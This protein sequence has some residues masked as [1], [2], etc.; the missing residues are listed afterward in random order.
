MVNRNPLFLRKNLRKFFIFGVDKKQSQACPFI[1]TFHP[2]PDMSDWLTIPERPAARTMRWFSDK[3]YNF[4]SEVNINGARV[5]FVLDR[6][7]FIGIVEIDEQQHVG[8][9]VESEY[10]R[11]EKL[12]Q[13]MREQ[14]EKD[15][16]RPI[17]MIRLNPDRYNVGE[18]TKNPTLENRLTFLDMFLSQYEPVLENPVTWLYFFFDTDAFGKIIS[19]FVASHEVLRKHATAII[20]DPDKVS[21]YPAKQ[22][23][24]QQRVTAK[25]GEFDPRDRCI[26][27]LREELRKSKEEL[28]L[29]HGMIS[30]LKRKQEVGEI[31]LSVLKRLKTEE[32]RA[33]VRTV[34]PPKAEVPPPPSGFGGIYLKERNGASIG[35]SLQFKHKDKLI[36]KHVPKYERR[37]RDKI[38]T[39]AETLRQKALEFGLSEDTIEKSLVRLG[40]K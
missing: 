11:T 37:G 9:R 39:T 30:A 7:H 19:P 28:K 36:A 27:E 22:L 32:P 34:S 20:G 16:S 17:I 12:L 21:Q 33:N 2:R 26:A 6:S 23:I 3:G 38:A 40:M 8:Y 5:D 35:Y 13:G 24:A 1:H 18:E 31:E 14:F 25:V 15:K 10:Q 29:Q 4:R